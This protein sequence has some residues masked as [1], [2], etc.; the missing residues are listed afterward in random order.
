GGRRA[1]TG[2]RTSAA[3]RLLDL[4]GLVLLFF[5]VDTL[6]A[7]QIVHPSMQTKTNEAV[8]RDLSLLHAL[9][10]Y[11]KFW[12]P[13]YPSLLWVLARAHIPFLPANTIFY[14]AILVLAASF[15]R[16]Y[17]GRRAALLAVV[18]LAV[19]EGCSW[20]LPQRMAETLF[21]LESVGILALLA[22]DRER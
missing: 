14:L 15:L 18:L 19:F 10:W 13:L 3:S 4:L 11:P 1:M 6:A 22:R 12:A 21:T 16:R 7:H 5:V 9:S 20:N 17:A 2:A 8:T